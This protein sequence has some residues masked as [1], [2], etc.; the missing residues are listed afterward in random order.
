M[1]AL[2]TTKRRIGKP[3]LFGI[4]ATVLALLLSPCLGVAVVMVVPGMASEKFVSSADGSTGPAF[5]L[6]L[7]VW[8]VCTALGLVLAWVPSVVAAVRGKAE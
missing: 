2:V 7:W 5:D 6:C 4:V 1:L 3:L 8:A